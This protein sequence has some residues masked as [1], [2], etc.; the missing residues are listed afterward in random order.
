LGIIRS[1][2]GTIKVESQVGEGTSF[3]VIFPAVGA[4]VRVAEVEHVEPEVWQGEGT[5]L[6]VDD[7][8]SIRNL[9]R[10]ILERAGLTVLTADDGQDAVAVFS[11][12]APQIHAVLL[13]LNMPGMD[14]VEVFR[15]MKERVP[16]V[17][18]VLCSG[19]NEQ[20]VTKRLP[21]HKPAAF[22]RK[23]YHPSEL[24]DRLRAIW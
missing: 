19:Y 23:P 14:G 2:N 8:P 15:Y 13:D 6:V 21:G 11:K 22:L 5:I 9:A 24:V 1:H 17:R 12:H 20:D 18:V 10:M 16:G 4:A 3:R 7:Q